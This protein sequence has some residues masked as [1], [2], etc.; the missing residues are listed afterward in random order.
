M[1][2][3]EG[4]EPIFS[5]VNCNIKVSTKNKLLLCNKELTRDYQ[6]YIKFHKRITCDLP[7]GESKI[8]EVKI[9]M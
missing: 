2:S 8:K 1:T 3:L 6:M 5:T 4:S 7:K 9:I